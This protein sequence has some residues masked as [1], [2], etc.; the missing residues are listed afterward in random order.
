MRII[1]MSFFIL[2]VNLSGPTLNAQAFDQGVV[3]LVKPIIPSNVTNAIKDDKGKLICENGLMMR[4]DGKCCPTGTNNNLWP[5]VCTPTGTIDDQIFNAG[6]ITQYCPGSE[7]FIVS[8]KDGNWISCADGNSRVFYPNAKKSVG[9]KFCRDHGYGY[10]IKIK[11]WGTVGCIKHGDSQG[12][13]CIEA[14]TCSF[15]EGK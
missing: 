8:D 9:S 4:N 12:N 1:A 14:G 2:A 5:T 6:D 7:M 15:S 13:G 11:P 3:N 10:L